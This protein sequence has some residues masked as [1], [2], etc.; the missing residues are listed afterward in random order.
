M[1]TSFYSYTS[2][3][4]LHP[5]HFKLNKILKLKKIDFYFVKMG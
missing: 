2:I 4:I 1:I 5:P 3:K